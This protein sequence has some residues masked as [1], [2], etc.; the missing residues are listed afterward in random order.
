[1]KRFFCL[2]LVLCVLLTMAAP[3][4]AEEQ[5]NT[6]ADASQIRHSSQV[7]MLVDLGLISGY[8]DGTFRPDACITRAEIA[9]LIALVS[10]ADPKAE[11]SVTFPD[12]AGNWA[13][14]YIRYC[15]EKGI[16]AGSNGLFRPGDNVTAQELAKMLLIAVGRGSGY[17]GAGWAEAVNRDA[18][19]LGLYDGFE[20]EYATPVTRDD[21]CLI[22]Y[23]AMH[24]SAVAGKDADGSYL[25]ALDDL[26]NPKSYLEVRFGLVR[27]TG[28][29]TGNECADLTAADG[30]KLDAGTTK[31]AGH[32]LFEVSSD[33]SLLG[34]TVDIFVQKG[35]V[36]G[37]PCLAS[38]EIAQTFSQSQK[39]A[40]TL[41]TTG[42]RTT[43]ETE[44]YSNFVR[45][46]EKILDS[47]PA[48]ALVTVVDHTGDKKIDVVLV[49]AFEKASVVRVDP[50]T[51]LHG[52]TETAAK[53]YCASD[54][55]RPGDSALYTE[56][57]GVG[58]VLAEQNP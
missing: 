50:L 9:K 6:F 45:T 13:E 47:L 31:L 41:K 39:L 22:I 51:V 55:F 4:G 32:K 43:A 15:A 24:C 10:T 53:Q 33:L 57:G 11:G 14:P 52:G 5:P 21:A 58:Y 48:G 46:D 18:E 29:M 34:R 1:M 44:Y 7:L 38:G 16:I 12:A 42:Y 40:D 26:M 23:N 54:F 35:K 49:T 2:L 17:T 25:Y 56:I 28:V 19:S 8:S 20:S 27:Y 30:G 3:V 36:V 37:L